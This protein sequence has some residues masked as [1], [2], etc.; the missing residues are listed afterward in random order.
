MA[1]VTKHNA[2]QVI[3]AI[4]GTGGIKTKIAE[5]LDVSRW[6]VDNYIDR[7]QSVAA[8][9]AEETE[10]VIDMAEDNLITEIRNGNF[11]AMRYYLSTK[12]KHRGYTER[13][14]I[15]GADGGKLTIEYVN[16]WRSHE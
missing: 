6:T 11:N 1:G 14:E 10:A 2:A 16:D 15:T 7:W 13:Q 9:Y 12:G 5:R 3:E 8:A 4:K